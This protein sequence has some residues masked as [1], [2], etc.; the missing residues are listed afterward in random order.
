MP[1]IFKNHSQTFKSP[2]KATFECH[3]GGF[4]RCDYACECKFS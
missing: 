2:T 4:K 3:F 1:Q